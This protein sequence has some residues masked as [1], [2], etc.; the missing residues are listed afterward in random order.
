MS[1]NASTGGKAA[2]PND[3]TGAKESESQNVPSTSK[4]VH[5]D[6]GYEKFA[7]VGGSGG[8]AMQTSQGYEGL[9]EH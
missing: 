7:T 6:A 1:D 5:R 3:D 2:P 4:M 9:A 8:A